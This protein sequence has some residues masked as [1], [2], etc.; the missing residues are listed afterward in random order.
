MPAA[1][2]WVAPRNDAARTFD[3]EGDASFYQAKIVTAR[4][5]ADHVLSQASGLSYTVVNGA[6]GALALSEEQF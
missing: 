5:Y 6:A 2:R 1:G 3:G 4:F